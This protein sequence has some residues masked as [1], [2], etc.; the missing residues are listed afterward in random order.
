MSDE[1]SY[2]DYI[3]TQLFQLHKI[4]RERN[5]VNPTHGMKSKTTG[6]VLIKLILL[7][8]VLSILLMLI[9]LRIRYY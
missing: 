1:F 3:Y 2:K 6:N 4:Y 7:P 5:Y 8:K 9:R